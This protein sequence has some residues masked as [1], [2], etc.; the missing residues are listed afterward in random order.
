[1]DQQD[2]SQMG[3]SSKEVGKN[4]GQQSL[5]KLQQ[6]TKIYN[7]DYT[8]FEYVPPN[9]NLPIHAVSHYFYPSPDPQKVIVYS[10]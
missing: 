6:I 5:H 1:M 4:V 8:N 7:R 10:S 3:T 9:T 2:S